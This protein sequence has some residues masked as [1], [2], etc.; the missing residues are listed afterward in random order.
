VW[1][2]R[3]G[4]SLVWLGV[5][6]LSLELVYVVAMNAVLYLGLIERAAST[7]DQR[8]V[9]SLSWG[10]AWSPWPG[11]AYLRDFEMILSDPV[12]EFRLVIAEAS[13]NVAPLE[14]LKSRFVASHI[15]ARGVGFELVPKVDSVEGNEARL[16]AF[17]FIRGFGRPALL[18]QPA[19]PPLTAEERD[20]LWVVELDDIDAQVDELWLAEFRYRGPLHLRGGFEFAPMR[21]LQIDVA[22]LDF[23]EGLMSIGRYIVSTALK[24]H[25]ELDVARVDLLEQRGVELLPSVKARVDLKAPVEDLEVVEFYAP[26]LNV[27]GAATLTAQLAFEAGH[28]APGS[29]AELTVPSVSARTEDIGFSGYLRATFDDS[30]VPNEPQLLA[31]TGGTLKLPVP[32]AGSVLMTLAEFTA[33]LPFESGS[34]TTMHLGRLRLSLKDAQIADARPLT[35]AVSRV[36]PILGPLILGRGP[37]VASVHAAMTPE[38]TTVWLNHAVLGDATFEGILTEREGNWNGAVAGHF[39]SVPVGLRLRKK[40]VTP[41]FFI[42]PQWLTQEYEKLGVSAE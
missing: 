38:Y 30:A 34:L 19:L 32:G 5:A 17:P 27:K 35:L 15:R 16:E 9:A 21:T 18:P 11:R 42:P 26:M 29:A 24:A 41:E 25:V 2:R 10:R 12:L 22:K 37:L 40:T 6:V 8:V 1:S 33:V 39:G 36:V 28:L 14:L 13:L 4:K 23:E 31:R 20:K 7:S 3:I